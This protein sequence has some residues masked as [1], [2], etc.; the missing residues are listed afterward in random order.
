MYIFE[1]LFQQSNKK[2]AQNSGMMYY[3][4]CILKYSSQE[5]WS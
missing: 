3:K 4:Q 1:N 5:S 2:E